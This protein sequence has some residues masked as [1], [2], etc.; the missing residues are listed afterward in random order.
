MP[1]K[2]K[3]KYYGKPCQSCGES[4]RYAQTPT[5]ILMNHPG[6]CVTCARKYDRE[7]KRKK[8]EAKASLHPTKPDP[9]ITRPQ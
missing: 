9:Q 3:E 6:K 7:Y 2:F 8:K 4:L 5:Q 1:H